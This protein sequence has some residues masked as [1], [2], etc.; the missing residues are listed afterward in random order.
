MKNIEKYEKE[1]RKSGVYFALTKEG[2]PVNCEDIYCVD[3]AFNVGC[4]IK[5]MNWLL[6]EY[7]EPI[8]TEKEKSYLKNAIEPIREEI[9]C[10][11]KCYWA[12]DDSGHAIYAVR[13]LRRNPI[14]GESDRV[15]LD[16]LTTEET[17]DMSFK[18]M[19][20]KRKYTIEELGL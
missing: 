4:V 12:S 15:L 13:V 9:A 14:F 19:E 3:C 2:S 17:E 10:V 20:L 1:L 16:F 8:L 6:E 18:N 11:V 5:R 7:K